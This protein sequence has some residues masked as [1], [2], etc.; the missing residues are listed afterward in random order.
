MPVT[1]TV[2]FQGG[3]VGKHVQT[4][5]VLWIAYS[6]FSLIGA[7]VMFILA[8]TLFRGFGP[9][10]PNAPEGIPPFLHMLF[11]ALGFLL[12][13]KAIAGIAAGAGLLNREPWARVLAIVMGVIAL[14]NIPI[15]L[16]MGIYTIWVLLSPN[17]DKEYNALAR[18]A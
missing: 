13:V 15:G 5:G 11:T 18:A 12:L 6:V 4:L 3:R 16:A 7:M 14:I 1:G 2:S 10:L 9:P 8:R 17:A